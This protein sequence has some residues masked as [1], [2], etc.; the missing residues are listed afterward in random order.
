MSEG[1]GLRLAVMSDTHYGRH[2]TGSLREVFAKASDE[3]DVLLLCGDLTDYGLVEEAEMLAED[4]RTSVKIPVLAVLGNHDFESGTPKLVREVVEKAGVIVLD[5]ECHEIDG[6]GFAGVSGFGGGF[7][8]TML[9]AWGEPLIK[10]FVQEAVNE[11]LKLEQALAKLRTERTVVLLHYSPIR[12]T[13]E[14]EPLEIYP[15]MGSSRLEVPLNQYKVQVAFHGHAHRGVLEGRT[16]E[17]IPV[18]NA[19]IPV[20]KRLRPDKPPFLIYDVTR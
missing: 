3:A 9:N 14:G 20:L 8:A 7:G 12:Q 5:G 4:L 2:A 6:I 18:F 11:S 13:I 16:S 17:G 19:S 10:Q 15:F 1:N